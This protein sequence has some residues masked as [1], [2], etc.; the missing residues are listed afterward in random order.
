M[1]WKTAFRNLN[2]VLMFIT[3]I[4]LFKKLLVTNYFPLPTPSCL[5]IMRACEVASVLSNSLQPYGL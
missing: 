2:K 3:Q 5:S 4:S 1:I